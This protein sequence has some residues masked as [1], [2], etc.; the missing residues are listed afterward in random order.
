MRILERL[1]HRSPDGEA[2]IAR[3]SRLT[4]VE[5]AA[6]EAHE[7]SHRERPVVLNRLRWLRGTEPLPG[8]DALEPDEIVRALADA[9]Q[10]TS[11]ACAHMNAAIAIAVTCEPKSRASCP[12]R[13]G[14]PDRIAPANRSPR[15]YRQ[16]FG[17]VRLPHKPV[18]ST[19]RRGSGPVTTASDPPDVARDERNERER[20]RDEARYRR[21]RLQLYRARLYAE[22]PPAR[23]TKGAPTGLRRSRSPSASGGSDDR[24]GRRPTALSAAVALQST[25]VIAYRPSVRSSSGPLTHAAELVA[26]VRDRGSR[27]DVADLRRQHRILERGQHAV[28]FPVAVGGAATDEPLRADGGKAS[29]RVSRTSASPARAGLRTGRA[30]LC[31]AVG[32]LDRPEQLCLQ[33]VGVVL[34]E[35]VVCCAERGERD[36]DLLDGLGE[37]VE[38]FR[39]A[40]AVV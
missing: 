28:G 31:A 21:E 26:H 25:A 5:L 1:R 17:P 7:R 30:R 11:S 22:A 10:A 6:V 38:Q 36:P 12:P 3:L 20:L 14:V 16:A 29:V 15:S 40:S 8:Y 35:L 39:L 13:R 18:P 32:G 24:I 2:G 19:A 9:D 34:V 23:T 33:P 27:L 4:Q 37:H